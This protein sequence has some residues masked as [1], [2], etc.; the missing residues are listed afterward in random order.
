[1]TATEYLNIRA[2]AV[3]LVEAFDTELNDV[4]DMIEIAGYIYLP[5]E[6]LKAID[7]TAYR[8][9][10]WNWAIDLD[11]DLTEEVESAIVEL[12]HRDD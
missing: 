1:M 5:A 11:L 3:K 9:T 6:L 8:L 2:E 10:F 7:Q 4:H 12:L